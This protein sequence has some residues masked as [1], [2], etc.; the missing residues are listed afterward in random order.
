LQLA[1]QKIGIELT[2][3]NEAHG[4]ALHWEGGAEGDV[5]FPLSE[6]IERELK[7]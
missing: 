6:A 2:I 4:G 7:K 1:F 5:G 3:L